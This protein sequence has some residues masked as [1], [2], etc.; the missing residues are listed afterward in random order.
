LRLWA[1]VELAVEPLRQAYNL[2]LLAVE[3]QVA[4]QKL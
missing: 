4:I 3:E 1:V 2:L